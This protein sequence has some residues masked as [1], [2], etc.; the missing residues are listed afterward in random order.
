MAG[1]SPRRLEALALCFL[2]FLLPGVSGCGGN[3]TAPSGGPVTSPNYPSNYG[4]SQGFNF[5]YT[6]NNTYAST[7]R[8]DTQYK[9]HTEAKTRDA[10]KQT[11]AADGGHL[12]DIKTEA[13]HNFLVEMINVNAGGGTDYWIGLSDDEG[14]NDFTWSDGTP[15]DDCGYS[16]WAPGEPRNVPTTG[17]VQLWSD[18]DFKWDDDLCG[19]NKSFICQK[20]DQGM[21]DRNTAVDYCRPDPCVNGTCT[22]GA[23][24]FT[25]ACDE[26]YEG[27]TCEVPITACPELPLPN[28]NRTEGHLYGDTISFSCKEGYELIGSENRTC[29]ANQSWSGVQTNCSRKACPELPFP[30]NGNRTE[31]HLYGDTVTFSCDEGYE[32]IGSENRTCQA[33]QSW[34]GVQTNCSRK[35]CPELPFPNNG[36]RTE[37]HLYGDTVTFSCDEGYELIGSENRTCQANQSWSGVQ[38]NCSRKACP[39]LP[40]PNNGNRTEGHLYGDTVTFSCDE[41]YELIGSENRTCQADQSWSGVQT[42]CS[43]KLCQQLMAP[44]NGNISGGSSYE[45]VVAYHC[46]PGYEISGDEERTCQSNQTWSGTQPTCVDCVPDISLYGG[47]N[48]ESSAV[49]IARRTAF[50][51]RSRINVIC[52]QT[53]DVTYEW[54]VFQHNPMGNVTQPLDFPNKVVR[55]SQDITIPRNSLGYGS[56]IVELN[57][58]MDFPTTGSKKSQVQKQWVIITPSAPVAHIAGGSAK[59]VSRDGVLVLNASESYDPDEYID[60][61]RDFTFHWTCQTS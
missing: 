39:E 43:R 20:G 6:S 59:S 19:Q 26:G 28:G 60:D 16:N 10:A 3:L 51:I 48:S 37:G 58:T 47:G 35:A 30:N 36:N 8:G 22:S 40:F 61:Y 54:N 13:L 24:N 9:I 33:D 5:S 44:S 53:Y 38:T 15:V 14:G 50:T 27:E 11:C 18:H 45:D 31:G 23:D 29:Q 12:V 49:K 1:S 32:L 56:T 17:C 4:N 55:D 7:Q 21:C 2:V 41:G 34:S 25:C 57:A 52:N 46:D 42:N